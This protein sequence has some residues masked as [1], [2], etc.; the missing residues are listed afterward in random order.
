MAN[1]EKEMYA[2]QDSDGNLIGIDRGSGGYPWTP[3]SLDGVWMESDPT[4]LQTYINC[5]FPGRFS[6]VKIK[7]TI[8]KV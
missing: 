8:E 4:Y 2:L 7:V 3:D 6:L 1:H 5:S